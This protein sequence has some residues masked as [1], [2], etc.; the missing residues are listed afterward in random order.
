MK[1]EILK[2]ENKYLSHT[3][4]ELIRP[5]SFQQFNYLINQYKEKDK[6]EKRQFEA[7]ESKTLKIRTR[8]LVQLTSPRAISNYVIIRH[9]DTD[10]K[11]LMN[12]DK[13]K[14]TKMGIFRI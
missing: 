14:W 8:V 1:I 13:H 2:E 11:L 12:E 10:A 4:R 5:S 7:N 9:T 3:T 6:R